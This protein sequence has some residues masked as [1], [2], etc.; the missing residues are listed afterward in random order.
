ML[1][2]SQCYG[3]IFCFLHSGPAMV[4]ALQPGVDFE[5]S[6]LPFM[7][8]KIAT[9]YDIPGCRVTRCGYT[10]EDGVEVNVLKDFSSFYSFWP[11]IQNLGL[12]NYRFTAASHTY[13]PVIKGS[14]HYQY[15]VKPV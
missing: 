3:Y 4:K 13:F 14:C 5:M 6:T 11:G 12:L 9:I 15:T 10:G 7:T 8:T 1:T 2:V